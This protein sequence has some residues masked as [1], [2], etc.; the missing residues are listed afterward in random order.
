MLHGSGKY[1]LSAK[2]R[3]FYLAGSLNCHGE[4]I[5]VCETLEDSPMKDLI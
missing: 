2:Q 3:D 1:P 5:I 4:L